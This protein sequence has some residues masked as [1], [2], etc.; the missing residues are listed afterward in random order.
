MNKQN[1]IEQLKNKIFEITKAEGFLTYI[2]NDE[3]YEYCISVFEESIIFNVFKISKG[4]IR[5]KLKPY[6]S[7]E[8]TQ[9]EFEEIMYTTFN[10][11]ITKNRL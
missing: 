5:K 3:V 6:E 4:L 7:F 1:L 9:K 8:L 2:Y 11:F 10:D